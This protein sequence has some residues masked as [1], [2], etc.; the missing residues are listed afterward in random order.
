MF[1]ANCIIYDQFRPYIPT[2]DDLRGCVWPKSRGGTKKRLKNLRGGLFLLEFL[3][4]FW[5]LARKFQGGTDF[6]NLRGG[7]P[8]LPPQA[9]MY[10]D[11]F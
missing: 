2:N 3:K 9:G 8:P 11:T 5:A 1:K 10:V 7:K 4:E 6:R